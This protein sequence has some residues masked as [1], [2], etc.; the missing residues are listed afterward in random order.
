MFHITSVCALVIGQT[1]IKSLW[2]YIDF[3]PCLS[4][5]PRPRG[6]IF[7]TTPAYLCTI[8]NQ[9]EEKESSQSCVRLSQPLGDYKSL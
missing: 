7:S 3:N 1:G 4:D 8:K 6:E 9:E 2:G 5:H